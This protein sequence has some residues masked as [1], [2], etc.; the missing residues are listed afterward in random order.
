MITAR[1]T[2]RGCARAATRECSS[3]YCP[4]A[5][6]AT[7]AK[8][9]QALSIIAAVEAEVAR[10]SDSLLPGAGAPD[11]E[12]ARQQRKIAILLGV[13][14]GHMIDSS[15]DNCGRCSPRRRYMTL[16][17]SKHT[18]WAGS[19]GDAAADD[20]GLTTLG[21]EIVFEMN[22][23]GMMV[24]VSHVSDKTFAAVRETCAAP[25]IASHSSCR[26]ISEHPRNMTDAML[27]QVADSG[28]VVHINYYNGFLED[29]FR[30]RSAAW[31]EAHKDEPA[32]LRE[33]HAK[34]PEALARA[35]FRR[36]MAKLDAIGRTPLAVLLDHF[37]H[38]V[39][40]MGV[41]HVGLGSDFDG[42]DEELPEGMED[43]SKTAILVEGLRSRGLADGDIS[44]I[45]GENTLRVMLDVDAAAK[46]RG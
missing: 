45:L 43:A 21:R 37:E 8:F 39:K 1:S 9:Q 33:E 12:R 42:V 5:R 40:V 19:S 34:D 23:L 4:G 27:K 35:L 36:Q 17:H 26:A 41:E 16:T 22:R 7:P 28:G 20:P 15:L 29:D 14:G 18:P 31:T 38:A 2:F 32:K 44:K 3:V 10:H 46:S 6:G 25:I 11:I 30:Q 13:E 24:D